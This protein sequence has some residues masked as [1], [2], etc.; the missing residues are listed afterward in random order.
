MDDVSKHKRELKRWLN[1]IVDKLINE[2]NAE[3]IILFGSMASDRIDETTDIDLVIVKKTDKKFLER[4]LE[5]G[6]LCL[7]R[8]GVDYF[9]YTPEEFEQMSEENPFFQ[10]E[11]LKKGKILY[12]KP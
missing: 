10:E 2:Y 1:I 8:I 7:A 12:E 5:V 6:M 4:C 11:V 3:K 9:V